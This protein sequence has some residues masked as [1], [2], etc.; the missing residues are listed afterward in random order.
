MTEIGEFPQKKSGALLALAAVEYLLVR[1][2]ESLNEVIRGADDVE[3]AFAVSFLA[4]NLA[5]YI[6]VTAA[7]PQAVV[8]EYRRE[9]LYG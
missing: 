3:L 8:A 6:A 2:D 4:G 9:V 5:A 1:D 7:D